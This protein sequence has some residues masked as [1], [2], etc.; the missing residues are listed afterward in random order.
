M[1]AVEVRDEDGVHVGRGRRRVG[2]APEVGHPWSKDRVGQQA[3]RSDLDQ[4]G[5]VTHIGDPAGGDGRAIVL[6]ARRTPHHPGRVIAGHPTGTKN[7]HM[8]GRRIA[9]T[10]LLVLATLLTTAF[11]FGAV[12]EA[13]GARHQQLGRY[14]QGAARGR[15]DPPGRG[16]VH[17][18]PALPERRGG[19]P[20]RAGASAAARPAR[21]ARRRRAEAGRGAERGAGARHGRRAQGLGDGQPDSAQD[22]A[23]RDRE[24]RR[25]G[26]GVARAE[27]PVRADGGGDRP[28]PLGGGQASAA[29]VVAP[30]RRPRPGREGPRPARRVQDASS[31]C[32]SCCRSRRSPARSRCRRTGAGPW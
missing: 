1:I 8:R 21:E 27:G 17:H 5:G 28:A 15:G 3:R 23:P 24:Q 7:R 9:V 31:G 29:G 32:C 2:V 10:A 16:P 12:G 20:D 30:G 25:R 13:A 26:R 6:A 22:A 19:R 4:H 11:G 18:R 14:E